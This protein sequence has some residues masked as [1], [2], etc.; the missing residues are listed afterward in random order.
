MLGYGVSQER[1]EKMA[2]EQKA[3]QFMKK[4][5]EVTEGRAQPLG[6]TPA[7]PTKLPPILLVGE[8]ASEQREQIAPALLK[9]LDAVLLRS[10]NLPTDDLLHKL[11]EEKLPWGLWPKGTLAAEPARL[12]EL[13][14]EF[15]VLGEGDPAGLLQE[16][17]LDWVLEVSSNLT[18]G[19]AR[20]AGKLPV[21]AV[22]FTDQISLPLKVGQLLNYQRLI[23]LIGKPSLICLIG[24]ISP[25]DLTALCEVGFRAIVLDLGQE[26]LEKLEALRKAI[27]TLRPARRKAEEAA[28]ALPL[29]EPEEFTG[30]E[31]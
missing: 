30:E 29:A 20:A 13:G 15:V 27:A 12:A 16:K 4:L 2:A 23:D 10:G 7:L 5:K 9:E 21:N 28:A 6:F 8:L 3:P 18:D 17:K 24:E 11:G 31:I 25:G 1:G 19:L 22:L 14:C 26:N